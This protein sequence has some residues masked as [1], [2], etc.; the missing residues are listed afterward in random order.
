MAGSIMEYPYTVLYTT[1]SLHVKQYHKRNSLVLASVGFAIG[2]GCWDSCP[3]ATTHA[4][5]QMCLFCIVETLSLCLSLESLLL[6]NFHQNRTTL[7]EGL[8]CQVGS[9]PLLIYTL[10]SIS[11]AR[12]TGPDSRPQVLVLYRTAITDGGERLN[13]NFKTLIALS[14]ENINGEKIGGEKAPRLFS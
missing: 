2:V 10:I 4:A 5:W 6:E 8:L 14:L 9:F 7:S 13:E 1:H 11:R 3:C 12:R